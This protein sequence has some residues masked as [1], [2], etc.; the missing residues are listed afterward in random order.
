MNVV[1]VTNEL[2]EKVCRDSESIASVLTSLSI[3]T[4]ADA[5]LLRRLFD[6][7]DSRLVVV[8][9]ATRLLYPAREQRG[10]QIALKY[11]CT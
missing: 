2:F 10:V 8:D 3:A 1:A 5:P 11:R 4:G 9:P 7:V 6:A